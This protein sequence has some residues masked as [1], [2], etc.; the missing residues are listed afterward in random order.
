M[1]TKPSLPLQPDDQALSDVYHQRNHTTFVLLFCAG[2]V[3]APITPS[4]LVPLDIVLADGEILLAV[5]DF[6]NVHGTDHAAPVPYSVLKYAPTVIVGVVR[7][8]NPSVGSIGG[9]ETS[10][11]SSYRLAG[12]STVV[13]HTSGL[14]SASKGSQEKSRA[15]EK[16]GSRL[17]LHRLWVVA[18]LFFLLG[19]RDT[20]QLREL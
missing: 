8:N 4:F 13:H 2:L 5:I 20:E 3:L 18:D 6:F 7:C 14:N 11:S 15:N 10:W 12:T 9:S 1:F 19:V 17:E 16:E